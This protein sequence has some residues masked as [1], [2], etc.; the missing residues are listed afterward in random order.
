[1]VKIHDMA[2]REKELLNTL[3][4]FPEMPLKELLAHTSYKRIT[5]IARK[6][7][8]LREKRVLFGPF[9]VVDHN[10]LCRNS[11]HRLFCIFETERSYETVMSYLQ[12]IQPLSW[13]FLVQSPYKKLLNV[14]FLSSNNAEMRDLFQLLKDNNIISDFIMRVH[15]HVKVVE[16]PNFF[17]DINP[18]L[19]GLLDPC[20][21]PDLSLGHCDTAWNE[22][23]IHVLPYLETGYKGGKLIEILRAERKSGRT[24]TYEQIKYSHQ[25]MIANKLIKK[26]YMIYPFPRTLCTIFILFFRTN[27]TLLTQRILCNFAAGARVYKHYV[28]CEDWATLT[29]V[30]HPSFLTDLMHNLDQ[31]VEIRGKELYPLRSLS[32]S[33][34]FT[35]PSNFDYFDV[36]TQRLEYPYHVYR[37]KIKEKL[38]S[39]SG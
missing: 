22:C 27:N 31:I 29:C 33:S 4:R 23:D 25:K 2:E 39:D 1:M 38:E 12:I 9:Y 32:K 3:G 5:S 34:T 37:E 18:S 13:T 19:D 6:F 26:I 11:L 7:R 10:K 35:L 16:N 30:C 20:E 15:H 17:G 21:L 28:L 36:D 24:W 8:Q 14:G